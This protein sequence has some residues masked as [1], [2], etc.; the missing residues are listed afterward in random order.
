MIF[1]LTAREIAVRP[2]PSPHKLKKSTTFPHQ[3]S[4]FPLEKTRKEFTDMLLE[5]AVFHPESI[6]IARRCGVDRIELCTDYAAGGLSPDPDFFAYARRRFEGPIMVMIR[7]RPGNFEYHSDE[8]SSMV[9]AIRRFGQAGA[10]G[11]VLGCLKDKSVD[12][13]ALEM[14]IHA[15]GEKPLTFHRAIDEVI[16][17]EEGMRQLISAGCRRVLTTGKATTAAEGAQ[18]LARLIEQFGQDIS[19]L[20]GGGI[21]HK[22]LPALLGIPGLNEIHTAAIQ[23]PS[24]P[25]TDEE[26]IIAILELLKKRSA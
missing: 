18:S 2:K 5:L 26:E 6:D 7:P 9:A 23:S 22:N 11:F 10:D 12:F 21:R 20:A 15:A 13:P 1:R 4:C 17:P 25:V 24:K 19:I 16:N 3:S 8:I 14:L